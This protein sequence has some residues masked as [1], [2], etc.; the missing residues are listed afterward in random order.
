MRMHTILKPEC[1][2]VH[3]ASFKIWQKFEATKQM[4][5]F[6]SK[7]TIYKHYSS[8]LQGVNTPPPSVTDKA[9]L[10]KKIN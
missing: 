10:C 2:V 3:E 4:G 7:Q 8:L 5:E 9:E 6:S 1:T